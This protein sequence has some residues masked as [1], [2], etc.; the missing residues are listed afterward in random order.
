MMWNAILRPPGRLRSGL[1]AL[2]TLGLAAVA[3]AWG[4]GVSNA[5]ANVVRTGHVDAELVAQTTAV[6]PGRPVYVA[7]HQTIAPGWHTYWRN[8][9]D[10][11]QAT[12][13]TW[14]LPQ[15]WSAGAIVWPA[16]ERFLAGP[17]M[18]YVYTGAV[19][20]PVADQRPRRRPAPARR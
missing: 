20:L 12:T 14:T 1:G 3:L 8:P 15:G 4:G 19:D 2:S 9:G 13:L 5:R 10:A 17:I 16:P 7:L 6:T 18:N 11:G